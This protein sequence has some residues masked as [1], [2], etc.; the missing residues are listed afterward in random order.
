MQRGLGKGLQSLIPSK[1]EKQ[2][3]L[4]KGKAKSFDW[5]GDRRESIFNIEVD[6]IKP[7]PNQPRREFSDMGLKE[8]A[9]SIKEHGVLQPLIV[10]KLEKTSDRGRQVEYELVAGERR[11]RA[12]KKA[13]LPHV[14]VI[15]RGQSEEK[16]RLE[17]ALI[18]NIQREN[19]T[20]YE[21]ALAFKH[22]QD[23]FGLTHSQIAKKIGKAR[24]TVSNMVRL[25]QLP[26]P[27]QQ[28]L[29][30]GKMNEGTARTLLMVPAEKRADFFNE[31]KTKKLGIRQAENRAQEINES[32]KDKQPKPYGKGPKNPRFKELEA[33]LKEK[34][35]TPVSITNRGGLGSMRIQF[36]NHD[37]LERLAD[38]LK[39]I[40]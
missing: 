7:N 26:E 19:L 10:S 17:I 5:M 20:P 16:E 28:A 8:L 2:V 36:A 37:E 9:D 30:A 18:E 4:S 13:G 12:A 11:W 39:K 1:N 27:A 40:K 34:I 23:E 38:H 29:A 35:G 24:P 6:K 32:Q 14:P 15:I 31:I 21:T 25:L 22:M 3:K 33:E